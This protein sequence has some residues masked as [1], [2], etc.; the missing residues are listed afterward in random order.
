[1]STRVNVSS[2]FFVLLGAMNGAIVAL[3]AS[4]FLDFVVTSYSTICTLTY[5]DWILVTI[6]CFA[7]IGA[8]FNLASAIFLY[9]EQTEK[10]KKRLVKRASKKRK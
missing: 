2:W 10:P 7:L 6:P 4:F 5:M 1:M 3:L 9:D 8:L